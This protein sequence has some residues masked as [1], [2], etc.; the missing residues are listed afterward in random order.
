MPIYTYRIKG[1]TETF[2]VMQHRRMPR[3]KFIMDV[4]PDQVLSGYR[5]RQ[6]E[7]LTEI[8]RIASAPGLFIGL[9]TPKFYGNTP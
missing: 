5:V 3:Y 1:T 4:P 7:A 8:E 9:P 6:W 2:D